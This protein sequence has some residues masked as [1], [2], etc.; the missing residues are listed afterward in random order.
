M[1]VLPAVSCGPRT[2]LIPPGEPVRLAEDVKA[3]VYVTVGDETIKSSN[4]VALPEG[5]YALPD[6]GEP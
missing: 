2:V 6:P 5:W 4:R 3:K 1:A